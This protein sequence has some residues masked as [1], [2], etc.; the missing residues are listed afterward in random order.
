MYELPS[1]ANQI[2]GLASFNGLDGLNPNGGVVLDSAGN[3]YGTTYQ[4]GTD[5]N[6]NGA[7]NVFEIANGSN[8]ISQIAAFGTANPGPA[9]SLTSD[10]SGDLLGTTAKGGPFNDGTAFEIPAGS[11]ALRPLRR[12]TAAT[13]Q[14]PWV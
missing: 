4:S 12:S 2:T 14:G 5:G 3:L 7:G 6:G 1:G 11:S 10:A 13:D 9:N 8:T